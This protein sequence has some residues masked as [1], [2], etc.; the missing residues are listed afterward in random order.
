MDKKKFI[1]HLIGLGFKTGD[2]Y[3]H[4]KDDHYIITNTIFFT[5]FYDSK[6]IIE[7]EYSDINGIYNFNKKFINIIRRNK[8][9]KILLK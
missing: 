5:Y 1:E 3:A 9:N 4:S 6:F 2:S 8:L 7:I